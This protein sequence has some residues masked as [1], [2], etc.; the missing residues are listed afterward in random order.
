MVW[1]EK[2]ENAFLVKF[3]T[4]FPSESRAAHLFNAN[5]RDHGGSEIG[6]NCKLKKKLMNSK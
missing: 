6:I 2:Y 4:R 3:H 5:L 1:Y